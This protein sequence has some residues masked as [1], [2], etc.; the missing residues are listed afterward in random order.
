MENQESYMPQL[1]ALISSGSPDNVELAYQLAC[2][3]NLKDELM[4]PWLDLWAV[5]SERKAED[6][7]IITELFSLKNIILSEKGLEEFPQ[8]L[9]MM[10]HLEIIDLS[11]NDIA[12]LPEELF[13]MKNILKLDLSG[14]LLESV[15]ENLFQMESLLCLNLRDNYLEEAPVS[16]GKIRALNLAGNNIKATQHPFFKINS[17][18]YDISGFFMDF[19]GL[20]RS[21]IEQLNE[22]LPE[23]LFCKYSF[24]ECGGCDFEFYIYDNFLEYSHEL[25]DVSSKH[26][27]SFRL[28]FYR[29]SVNLNDLYYVTDRGFY[30]N[31]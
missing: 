18:D 5:Y 2:G 24:C 17:A 31:W 14:N 1:K 7:Q 12:E 3:L 11:G 30:C 8:T 6:V 25:E 4:Q 10:P 20:E 9:F 27:N 23:I 16:T 22:L 13:S 29:S 26:K 15:P 28:R 21:K 19:S